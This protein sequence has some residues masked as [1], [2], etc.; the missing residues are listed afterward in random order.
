[1][2]AAGWSTSLLLGSSKIL[3]TAGD[4]VMLIATGMHGLAVAGAL[5][6]AIAV[7]VLRRSGERSDQAAWIA[8]E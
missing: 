7:H 3:K 1:M 4:E 5:A 8:A 2:S 6:M